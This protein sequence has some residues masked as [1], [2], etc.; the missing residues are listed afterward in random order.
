MYLKSILPLWYIPLWYIIK[1]SKFDREYQR[2]ILSIHITC[3]PMQ[4]LSSV[5]LLTSWVDIT[6]TNM[7]CVK[8][9]LRNSCML[10]FSH[11]AVQILGS[12]KECMALCIVNTENWIAFWEL[13]FADH[14]PSVQDGHSH[15]RYFRIAKADSK[16]WLFQNFTLL[17]SHKPFFLY[18]SALYFI[19]L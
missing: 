13:T 1:V 14:T 9:V 12:R 16:T 15:W 3:S 8:F 5:H 4:L 19:S 7:S 2:S 10:T 17:L 6:A 11:D 18:F